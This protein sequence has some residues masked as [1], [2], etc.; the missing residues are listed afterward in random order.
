MFES[1]TYDPHILDLPPIPSRKRQGLEEGTAAAM[2]AGGN[3]GVRDFMTPLGVTGY[4][5]GLSGRRE[6][7][8][9]FLD[10]RARKYA[11]IVADITNRE[12]TIHVHTRGHE[13]FRSPLP[14][15]ACDPK[16]RDLLARLPKGEYHDGVVAF[17]L[18]PG[19]GLSNLEQRFQQLLLARNL[20]TYLA[21]ADGQRRLVEAGYPAGARLF[22]DYDLIGARRRSLASEIFCIRPKRE[23]AVLL[24][25]LLEAIEQERRII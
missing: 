12:A 14:D 7:D 3:T 25:A 17:R 20:N 8:E 9:R 10:L 21:T 15:P 2:Y 16:A 11:A 22:T 19:I 1:N 6:V 24:M 5:L 23:I 18:P 4:K 13:W